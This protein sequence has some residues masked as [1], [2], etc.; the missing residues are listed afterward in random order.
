MTFIGRLYLAAERLMLEARKAEDAQEDALL[1][2]M[3][4]IG[5]AMTPEDL[6]EINGRNPS[7]PPATARETEI[8]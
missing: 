3:D 6:A 7:E 5:N 1:D 4:R 2:L 8:R